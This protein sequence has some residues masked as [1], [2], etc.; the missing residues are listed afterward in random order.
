VTF[1]A[2]IE[3]GNTEVAEHD[4]FGLLTTIRRGEAPILA[5]YEGAYAATTMTVMGNREGFTWKQPE[6][7]NEIDK[8]VAKKWERMKIEPSGL[9]S[10]AEFIRRVY[11]DLIGL[12]PKIAQVKAFLADKRPTRVKREELID[13]LI[14]SE[15]YIE[16]W[17]N[18]WAD[19]LQVNRKF[20]GPQGA[21]GFR[22]WIRKEIA[23]NRPYDVFARSI[24]EAEGSNK[25]N[26]AASYFKVLRNPQDTMENVS[27]DSLAFV[28]NLVWRAL[29][30]IEQ[31]FYAP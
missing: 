8:L 19:L 6:T 12:P 31:K 22:D 15:D 29:P 3:S 11:L 23:E 17:T 16:Y 28:G 24:L 2:F 25:D 7:W 27:A 30:H 20:L 21:K 13:K 14:G 4:D 26:P 18:K 10:D 5:R 1:E 9:C